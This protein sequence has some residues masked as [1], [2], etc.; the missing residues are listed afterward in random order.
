LRVF[1]PSIDRS[2]SSA[3]DEYLLNVMVVVLQDITL[4]KGGSC[5]SRPDLTHKG[6]RLQLAKGVDIFEIVYD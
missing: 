1:T 6:V 4:I 2:L 5:Q 3:Y